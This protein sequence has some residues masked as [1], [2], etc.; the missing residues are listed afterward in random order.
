MKLMNVKLIILF[1]I[2]ICLLPISFAAGDWTQYQDSA[3]NRGQVS[4]LYSYWNTTGYSTSAVVGSAMQPLV[5]DLT[6]D[7]D[8]EVILFSGNYLSIYDSEATLIDEVNIGYPPESTPAIFEAQFL[9][10]AND[11]LFGYDYNGTHWIKETE[12][13]LTACGNI[14][15]VGY[16]DIKCTSSKCYFTCSANTVESRINTWTDSTL[17][18]SQLTNLTYITYPNSPAIK[19]ID[20]D[21]TDDIIISK[22]DQNGNGEEGVCVIDGSSM[23]MSDTFGTY[24]CVDD[25]N[26]EF[27]GA[28]MPNPL[29]YNLDGAGDLEIIVLYM[30]DGACGA[31]AYQHTN[32]IRAMRS[33]GSTYWQK[34]TGSWNPWTGC[35]AGEILCCRLQTEWFSDPFIA[36]IASTDKICFSQNSVAGTYDHYGCLELNGSL[37]FSYEITGTTASN[38]GLASSFSFAKNT[39]RDYLLFG[40]YLVEGGSSITHVGSI[41]GLDETY[42]LAG[43]DITN[44]GNIDFISMKSGG[45]KITTNNYTACGNDNIDIGEECDGEDLEGLVCSDVGYVSGSLSCTS[46]C[47]YNYTAC[48][49]ETASSSSSG[50]GGSSWPDATIDV[51]F[52][53]VNVTE[54]EEDLINFEEFGLDLKADFEQI[55]SDPIGSIKSASKTVASYGLETFLVLSVGGALLFFAQSGANPLKGK[56]PKKIRGKKK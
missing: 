3:D 56:K 54:S 29:V 21:G 4:D 20:R 42:N 28:Y 2:T 14:A 40:H 30:R 35:P 5:Y 24:G 12:E 36:N 53:L 34:G 49:N 6:N 27:S 46:S 32:A 51:P 17:S 13:N 31:S 15:G 38:F 19:D 43:A 11:K 39:E 25:L 23:D 52:S 50:G 9:F 37:A 16:S 48:S 8:K 1:M 55:T 10:I 45:L 18:S 22:I 41:S 44:S 26:N 47:T 33:D 7:G